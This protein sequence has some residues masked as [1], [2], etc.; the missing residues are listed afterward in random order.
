MSIYCNSTESNSVFFWWKEA[1]VCCSMSMKVNWTCRKMHN[2]WRT[3]REEKRLQAAARSHA[4][5]F[6][7]THIHE[8]FGRRTS[9][10][11]YVCVGTC[12][13]MCTAWC[14][15]YACWLFD[16]ECR[17][18]SWGAMVTAFC[19]LF[20]WN[21]LLFGVFGVCGCNAD[22]NR[23]ILSVVYIFYTSFCFIH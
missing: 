13:C 14:M 12:V 17:W 6:E 16:W 9:V 21:W 8:M 15:M 19:L 20:W 4:S 10:R 23:N 2:L 22:Q 18:R 3:F 5:N 1:N 7:L 11:P